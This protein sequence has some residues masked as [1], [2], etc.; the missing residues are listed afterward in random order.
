M[1]LNKVIAIPAIDIAAGIGLA[2]CG[3]SGGS[4]GSGSSPGFYGSG[5]A[6]SSSSSSLTSAGLALADQNLASDGFTLDTAAS[7]SGFPSD[8]IGVAT[9]ISGPSMEV[10]FV[11]DNDSDTN[12]AALAMGYVVLSD[13]GNVVNNQNGNDVVMVDGDQQQVADIIFSDWNSS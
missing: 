1:K 2:A 13:G 11:F 3:S 8:V 9:S 5:G 6:S 7:T 12:S 4:P 10:V